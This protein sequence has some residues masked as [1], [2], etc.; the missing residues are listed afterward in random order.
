M[1]FSSLRIIVLSFWHLHE[2]VMEL[3][4]VEHSVEQRKMVSVTDC[5]KNL[6]LNREQR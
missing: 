4:H 5:K 2:L 3:S 1:T 6:A